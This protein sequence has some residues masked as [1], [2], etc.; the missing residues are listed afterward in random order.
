MARSVVDDFMQNMRFFVEISTDAGE[1]RLQPGGATSGFN[2]VTLPEET[3]EQ[4][5][6]REGHYVYTR[7]YPANPSVSDVTLTRG[8]TRKD[9]SFWDWHRQ[10]AQG[11]GQYRATMYIRTYHR[12]ASLNQTFRPGETSTGNDGTI[13]E[14]NVGTAAPSISY[15]CYECFPIRHKPGADLDATSGD[16]SIMELDVSLEYFDIVRDVNQLEGGAF[17]SA[18]S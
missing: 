14:I 10:T 12:D 4:V 8:V 15:V 18:V 9:S 2:S 11:S 17:A 1:Q 16:V 7:K 3:I 6:Y 13:F 5:E